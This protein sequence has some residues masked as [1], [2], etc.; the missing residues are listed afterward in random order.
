MRACPI[1][2][3][4]AASILGCTARVGRAANPYPP[5]MPPETLLARTFNAMA[6]LV[7]SRTG[8]QLMLLDSDHWKGRPLLDI[9]SEPGQVRGS[10]TL[11]RTRRGGGALRLH[12][13]PPLAMLQGAS[14]P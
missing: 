1:P 3:L 13:P 10:F 2:A 4:P 6:P 8:Y 5:C 7:T 11:Q 9:M 12:P 14:V